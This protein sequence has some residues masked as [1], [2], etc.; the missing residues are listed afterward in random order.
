MGGGQSYTGEGK[1]TLWSYCPKQKQQVCAPR[2]RQAD[3]L[4]G[5]RAFSGGVV[6]AVGGGGG[7]LSFIAALSSW[8]SRFK[9]SI[10]RHSGPRLPTSQPVRPCQG[11]LLPAPAPFLP[12]LHN[13]PGNCGVIDCITCWR[14]WRCLINSWKMQNKLL[15]KQRERKKSTHMARVG[16]V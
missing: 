8:Q 15:E 10:A 3:V 2:K 4:G 9:V 6:R 1:K 14:L 11:P 16:R 13:C 12:P 5:N 7:T